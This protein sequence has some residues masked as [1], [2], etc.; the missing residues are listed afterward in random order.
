MRVYICRRCFGTLHRCSDTRKLSCP[1]CNDKVNI[2][3]LD[4]RC[5]ADR[6]IGPAEL[7]LVVEARI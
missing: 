4:P 1:D 5:T 6:A 2:A 3:S 7:P